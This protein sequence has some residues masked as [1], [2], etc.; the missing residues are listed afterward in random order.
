MADSNPE[1]IEAWNANLSWS[2]LSFA[3]VTLIFIGIT[4]LIFSL[5]NITEISKNFSKYRCNPLMMPFAGQFGYDAKENFQFCIS[6][7]LNS[8]A[9]EIFAPLYGLL[10]QFVGI[11]TVM[12]NAT[13]GIRKLFSNFFLSVNN[14]VGNVRNK[15]QNLLLQI[16]MSFLKLN[17]LMGRVFGTMYAVIFMGMSALTAANNTANNDLVQFLAEFCFDP[18]TPVQ[19]EDGSYLPIKEIHIGHRLAPVNDNIPVVTSTFVFDGSKT[20]MVSIDD[21]ILS[22]EHYVLNETEWIPASDHPSAKPAQSL[23]SLV[24]L[25]VTGNKFYIGKSGLLARDYD[26]HDSSI[27]ATQVQKIAERALNGVE[28]KKATLDYGLGFDSS[29]EVLL[30]NGIWKPAT[31]V[32]I[33]DVIE[34]GAHIVGIVRERCGETVELPTGSK[35]SSAQLV[36][37]GDK[38]IRAGTAGFKPC[39]SQILIQLLTSNCGVITVRNTGG[40]HYLRDYREVPLPEMEMPYRENITSS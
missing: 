22:E 27:V 36:Y 34:G 29:F 6:N 17:N 31:K 26:E 1:L 32:K 39:G 19:I 37:Y 30:K 21:V 35:V 12:M 3:V 4:V 7:Q 16:R 23:K 24:C 38:W 40:M 8:K 5:S 13:L 18:N 15:I 20:S 11:L 10:S 2:I 9:A 28:G 14:F 33:G 25:N